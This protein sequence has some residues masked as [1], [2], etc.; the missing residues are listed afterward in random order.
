MGGV[1]VSRPL[2]CLAACLVAATA[3]A[4]GPVSGDEKP[5][6]DPA[7]QKTYATKAAAAPTVPA[8]IELPPGFKPRK[9]G[10]FIVYCRSDAPLGSR[11]KQETCFDEDQ[12]RDYLIALQ[13]TKGNVDRIRATCSNVC[14]CGQPDAC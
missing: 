1:V 13:E 8:D 2:A 14:T 9:R 10:K 4:Q 7:A 3:V 11:I 5:P 6:A 12:I